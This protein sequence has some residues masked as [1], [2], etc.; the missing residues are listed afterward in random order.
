MDSFSQLIGGD[1]TADNLDLVTA[2]LETLDDVIFS[3][4]DGDEAALEAAQPTWND[5][6]LSLGNDAVE[7]SRNQYLRYA[8]TTW[9]KLRSQALQNPY[10][11]LAVV[12]IIL[13][14]TGDEGS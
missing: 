10:R 12:R 14:L 4:I 8:K 11:I 6:I 5:A 7:E 2:R 13:L 1:Q 9:M 3:A